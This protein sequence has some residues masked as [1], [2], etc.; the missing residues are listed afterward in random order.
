MVRD[1]PGNPPL[2]A[3]NR[4]QPYFSLIINMV[5]DFPAPPPLSLPSTD[6]VCM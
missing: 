1:F 3:L 6:V 2:L 4:C 5:R